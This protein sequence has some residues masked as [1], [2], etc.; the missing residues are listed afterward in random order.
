MSEL[1]ANYPSDTSAPPAAAA[2]APEMPRAP[3]TAAELPPTPMAPPLVPPTEPASAAMASGAP[4]APKAPL[5]ALRGRAVS[6]VDGLLKSKGAGQVVL[7]APAP[8][9]EYAGAD[10]ELLRLQDEV[11]YLALDALRKKP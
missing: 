1:P 4:V 7:P 3:S 2:S 6:V 10:G 5:A 9:R 11:L 8:P